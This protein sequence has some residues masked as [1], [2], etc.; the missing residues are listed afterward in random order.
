MSEKLI[1]LVEDESSLRA[2]AKAILA[3]HWRVVE[4]AD[5]MDALA[6]V[7]RMDGAIDALVTDINMPGMDGV[8]L[9]QAVTE[10]YPAI[11]VVLM[12]GYCTQDNNQP[13]SVQAFVRKPFLP[14]HLIEAVR[15]VLSDRDSETD[16]T[17]G[18]SESPPNS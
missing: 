14:K 18:F 10:L 1:L 6:R 2:L 16:P 4:S 3:R 9:A 11:P 13:K 5:G 8:Q 17:P 15:S 12:S 7:C